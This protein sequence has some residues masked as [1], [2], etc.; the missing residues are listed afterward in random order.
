MNWKDDLR[1]QFRNEPALWRLIALNT[2]VFLLVAITRLVFFLGGNAGPGDSLAAF[3]SLRSSL[4]GLASSPWGLF[5]YMFVHEDLLHYLFNMLVLYWTGRIFTEF[6]GGVKLVSVYILGGL[7]GGSLYV[8]AYNF[9][10]AFTHSVEV[11][12]LIGASAGV[13]SVLVAIA[14][15]V[16]DYSVHLILLGPVRIKY[17]ALFLF[18]LYLISIPLGNAGG[19]ISHI[20]GALTGFIYTRALRSGIKPGQ[21]LDWFSTI[22]S[23]LSNRKS[24]LR[25]VHG[26][27]NK[28]AGQSVPRQEVI[29]AILDK[30]S[31]S[32]Y[33]SLSKDEKETLF[34]ASKEHE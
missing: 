3:L 28:P 13:C 19:N 32:G 2:G 26:K 7:V 29:D 6:L 23:S 9:F 24:R 18:L 5:T 31:K 25:M 4:S 20:G 12:R 21:W 33:S 22:L 30:I 15:L 34:K 14:T 8:A 17:I 10:P 16:P 1:I 27:S 11:S